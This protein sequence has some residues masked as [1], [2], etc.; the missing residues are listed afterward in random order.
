MPYLLFSFC[1][2]MGMSI[3]FISSFVSG[4]VALQAA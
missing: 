2:T 3:V 1:K 4:S